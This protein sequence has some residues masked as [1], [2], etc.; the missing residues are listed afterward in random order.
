MYVYFLEESLLK[1]HLLSSY[2]KIARPMSVKLVG[3]SWSAFISPGDETHKSMDFTIG[4]LEGG[5]KEGQYI[6][7]YF[8]LSQCQDAKQPGRKAMQVR[9][10]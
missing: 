3:E 7:W 1:T 9:P 2:Y 6:L 8:S 5:E 4:L 10:R